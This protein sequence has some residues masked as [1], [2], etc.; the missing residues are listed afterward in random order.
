VVWV[1]VFR[2]AGGEIGADDGWFSGLIQPRE[3]GEG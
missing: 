3:E 2:H 1:A